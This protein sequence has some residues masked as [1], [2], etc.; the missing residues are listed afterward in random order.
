[1]L[2]VA[3]ALA[4]PGFGANVSEYS[5]KAAYLCNFSTAVEWPEEAFSDEKSPLVIGVLGV[6]PFEGVLEDA[7]QGKK[8]GD[9]DLAVKRFGS[10]DPDH[11]EELKAC[12]ILF[13][14]SS[15]QDHLKEILKGL[16]G[17]AL[18]TVSEIEQFPAMGGMI[19][20][21]QAGDR[22]GLV[23]N[24]KPVKKAGLNLSP[25][26]IQLSKLYKKVNNKRVKV[27]F[28]E[29]VN[30]YI[31]GKISEAIKIWEECLDEDPDNLSVQQNLSKAKAKLRSI[32]NLN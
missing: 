1:M 14:A 24:R 4:V 13:I 10:F 20:F 2:T 27:L 26:L 21:D 9:R 31:N 32:S 19:S 11:I 16:K 12:Q 22:I 23:L 15:E 30:L 28:F 29:G 17:S 25:E 7:I 8:A 3:L 6:D 18:L 5:V